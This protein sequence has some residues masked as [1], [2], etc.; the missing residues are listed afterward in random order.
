[1]LNMSLTFGGTRA[2]H[3]FSLDPVEPMGANG[4]DRR[5]VDLWLLV[6]ALTR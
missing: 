1:M 6:D 3:V 2:A 4:G 5:A